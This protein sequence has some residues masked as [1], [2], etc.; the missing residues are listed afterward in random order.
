MDR[1]K[2]DAIRADHT[3]HANAYAEIFDSEETLATTLLAKHRHHAHDLVKRAV[4]VRN[5]KK[6]F[7]VQRTRTFIFQELLKD[8]HYYALRRTNWPPSS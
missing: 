3:I 1:G 7:W 2:L 5:T 6:F 4:K 8:L